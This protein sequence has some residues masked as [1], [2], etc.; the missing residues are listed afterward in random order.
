MLSRSYILRQNSSIQLYGLSIHAQSMNKIST[1]H[2]LCKLMGS[3]YAKRIGSN[4]FSVAKLILSTSSWP[5]EA[6]ARNQSGNYLRESPGNTYT[7]MLLSGGSLWCRDSPR[8]QS[9]ESLVLPSSQHNCLNSEGRLCCYGSSCPCFLH[10]YG[11]IYSAE[12]HLLSFCTHRS[13]SSNMDNYYLNC[14]Q[15]STPWE[16][17]LLSVPWKAF[18]GQTECWW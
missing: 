11:Y 14:P 6:S 9:T 10:S 17:A 4:Y 12:T 8:T 3:N 1:R 16:R 13:G 15:Y 2:W 5:Q 7:Y 18:P